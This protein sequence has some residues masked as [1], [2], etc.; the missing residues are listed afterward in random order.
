MLLKLSV[1]VCV[2][3]VHIMTRRMRIVIVVTQV[4]RL[5]MDPN[6]IIV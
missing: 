4:A 5:V 6:F 1:D 2:L 3:V